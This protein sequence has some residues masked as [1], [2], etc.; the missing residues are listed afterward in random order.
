MIFLLLYIFSILK[1]TNLIAQ[2]FKKKEKI[3][4]KY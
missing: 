3:N 2:K 1:V 4:D